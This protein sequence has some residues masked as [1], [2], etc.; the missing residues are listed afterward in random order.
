MFELQ[1]F[2]CLLHDARRKLPWQLYTRDS[3]LAKALVAPETP[4]V[5][6]C[7]VVED[8]SVSEMFCG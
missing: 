4:D 1:G 2:K 7:F 6:V 3:H 5:Q 8:F